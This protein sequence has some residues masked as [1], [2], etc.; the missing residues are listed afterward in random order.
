M[1]SILFSL[2]AVATILFAYQNCGDIGGDLG[3]GYGSQCD[4][5]DPSCDDGEGIGTATE[6]YL[7]FDTNGLGMFKKPTSSKQLVLQGDC[8]DGG[9]RYNR[10]VWSLEF[11]PASTQQESKKIDSVGQPL[12]SCDGES[13]ELRVSDLRDKL[14]LDPNDD[15]T[16]QDQFILDAEI[17]GFDTYNR[18]YMYPTN[19]TDRVDIDILQMIDPPVLDT[20]KIVVGP[21][22]WAEWMTVQEPDP[23]NPGDFINVDKWISKLQILEEAQSSHTISDITISGYCNTQAG[24]NGA[25]Q[26]YLYERVFRE[27]IATHK[28]FEQPIAYLKCHPLSNASDLRSDYY[29]GDIGETYDGY[30]Q[31]GSDGSQVVIPYAGRFTLKSDSGY[32]GHMLGNNGS[33]QPHWTGTGI[34][35][36][37]TNSRHL[38]FRVAQKDPNHGEVIDNSSID[39][40]YEA[41]LRFSDLAMGRGWTFPIAKQALQ[42]M[43]WAVDMNWFKHR[44]SDIETNAFI[45]NNAAGSQVGDKSTYTG[46]MRK[47]ILNYMGASEGTEFRYT[48]GDENRSAWMVGTSYT[49]DPFARNLYYI[50][51]GTTQC[52]RTVSDAASRSEVTITVNGGSIKN[53]GAANR[54]YDVYLAR[55]MAYWLESA[56]LGRNVYNSD[57]AN[58]DYRLLLT[59]RN[60][61]IT[62]SGDNVTGCTFDSDSSAFGS[63]TNNVCQRLY[64]TYKAVNNNAAFYLGWSGETKNESIASTSSDSDI[65]DRLTEF[66]ESITQY[67]VNALMSY[68]VSQLSQPGDDCDLNNE[69][70]CKILKELDATVDDAVKL[71]KFPQEIP[72]EG[73]NADIMVMENVGDGYPAFSPYPNTGSQAEV[74]DRIYP[75]SVGLGAKDCD[76]SGYVRA[77][78]G[79]PMVLWTPPVPVE[80][81]D[82]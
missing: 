59:T 44:T 68:F 75:E 72:G 49:S 58:D 11:I 13:F 7:R 35:D 22:D 27:G 40:E 76:G 5:N 79:N 50:A 25:V 3:F 62:V 12:L 51:K 21:N 16:D 1:K 71:A 6:L 15:F 28:V 77:I 18:P 19:G 78:D 52:D 46:G 4:E 43:R 63:E 42:H 10:I 74:A 82:D 69:L 38:I 24:N 53:R 32:E 29:Y 20:Y 41:I 80:D 34:L 30:F 73:N 47:T 64:N 54:E 33:S 45:M 70:Q 9:F 48:E 65:T 60:V 39:V 8:D 36:S 14:G 61:T 17:I 37:G 2:V 57:M 31:L 55:C 81:Q 23:Q 66:Y 26:V 67:Y 56:G